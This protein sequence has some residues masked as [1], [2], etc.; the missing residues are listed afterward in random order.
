MIAF[1]ILKDPLYHPVVIKDK[2]EFWKR[3]LIVDEIMT[4]LRP[5]KQV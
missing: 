5:S 2:Q 1:N 3:I 4:S